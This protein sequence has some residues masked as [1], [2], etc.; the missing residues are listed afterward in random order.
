MSVLYRA[1]WR[2]DTSTPPSDI[3]AAVR[4]VF[5]RWAADDPTVPDLPDGESSVGRR[6]IRVRSLHGGGI[7]EAVESLEASVHDESQQSDWTTVVR[8]TATDSTLEVLVDTSM[9]TDDLDRR[10]KVGRPRVVSELLTLGRNPRIGHSALLSGPVPISAGEVSALVDVLRDPD[11]VLPVVVFTHTLRGA[12]TRWAATAA[13]RAEGIATV[14]TLDQP[15]VS[16]LRDQLGELGAWGGA[17]RTYLP[18]PLDGPDDGWRHRYLPANRFLVSEESTLDRIVFTL[19]QLSTRRRVP[20][21]LTA[22]EPHPDPGLGAS[23]AQWEDLEFTLELEREERDLLERELAKSEGHRRRQETRLREL[24][25][26]ADIWQTAEPTTE[27]APDDVQDTSEA[28]LAA[29]TYLA[30]RIVIPDAAVQQLEGIDTSPSAYAWANTT[31]RGLLSLADFVTAQR[32]G[33]DGDFW[34]FCRTGHGGWPA[35]E[36]KLA[37]VESESVRAS[38]KLSS[39]RSFEVDECVDP[40]GRKYMESHLKIS[41]GGGDLAPRVYFYDDTKGA[42]GLMHVGFIGPHHLVPNTRT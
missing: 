10:I 33:F 4:S 38:A 26:Y 34:A 17:V 14:V 41:E 5:S 16:A 29:Q 8:A 3:I 35:T 18:A 25:A 23:A 36:K 19:A 27:Q 21:A 22:F 39:A 31:W 40:S 2:S 42:T 11:R 12:W 30:D 7:A 20:A 6:T 1:V 13:T 9:Q 15:A 24:G 28:V 32:G 37:M